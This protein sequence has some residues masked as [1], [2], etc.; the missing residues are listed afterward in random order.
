MREQATGHIWRCAPPVS[1]RL[2]NAMEIFQR[3]GRLSRKIA[4][5]HWV[6]DYPFVRFGRCRVGSPSRP[7]RERPAR[8]GHLY[9]PGV[10][11]W[12]DS[13]KPGQGPHHEAYIVFTGGELAGL[14]RLADRRRRYARFTDPGGRL[15]ALLQEA[16]R[17]GGLRGDA[18]FWRAQAALCAVIDLLLRC[19]HVE[20]ET[21]GVPV[22][23]GPPPASGLVRAVEVYLREHLAERVALRDIA[24]HLYMSAS[25]LSHR[26]SAESGETPMTTLTRLRIGV[27]RGLLLKNYPLKTIAAQTGFSDAFHLSKT[28]KRVEGVS[29]REFLRALRRQL[30]P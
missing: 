22:S 10:P 24:G 25:S 8:T 12:E 11:Y 27:A 30:A 1:P 15:G 28:F 18:G 16:A 19:E 3:G 23:E 4:H 26:Y 13:R 29:P 9:P 14:E 5:P 21:Y 2:L 20:D 6:L 17:A 7:W